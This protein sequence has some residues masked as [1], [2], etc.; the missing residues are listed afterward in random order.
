MEGGG[1]VSKKI[2]H[3]YTDEIVCPYCG[4][5]FGDS[6]ELGDEGD[7]DCPDCKKEFKFWQ[8]IEV[9]YCTQ[10]KEVAE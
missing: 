4:C 6:N 2:D 9:T 7:A 10:K 3:T 1:A 5:E 8:N